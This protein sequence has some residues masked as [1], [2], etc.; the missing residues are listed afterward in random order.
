MGVY[1]AAPGAASGS[2][3]LAHVCRACMRTGARGWSRNPA[4]TSRTSGSSRRPRRS[5]VSR[6]LSASSCTLDAHGPSSIASKPGWGAR[7]DPA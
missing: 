5:N 4:T 2:T 1:A 7:T 3:S 6:T